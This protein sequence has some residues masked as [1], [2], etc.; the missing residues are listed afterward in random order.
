MYSSLCTET[1]TEIFK[2]LVS[3]TKSGARWELNAASFEHGTARDVSLTKHTSGPNGLTGTV[4]DPTPHAAY[5][6]T[7]IFN[8]FSTHR[9]CFEHLQPDSNKKIVYFNVTTHK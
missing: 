6:L 7:I 5:A 8:I 9:G 1:I 2:D 3:A 4:R